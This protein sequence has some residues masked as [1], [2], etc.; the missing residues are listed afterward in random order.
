[1]GFFV[2]EE[3]AA[4]MLYK[5]ME[6]AGGGPLTPLDKLP[7]LP[8][9]AR[10]L[11]NSPTAKKRLTPLPPNFIR[12]EV[13]ENWPF[14]PPGVPMEVAEH[15]PSVAHHHRPSVPQPSDAALE[16]SKGT[17]KKGEEKKAIKDEKKVIKD[18]KKVIKDEKKLSK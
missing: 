4:E 10:P 3:D 11:A 5:Q 12:V 14:P 16:K 1:V 9:Y 2:E 15:R 18:E 13:D 7:P 8:Y 6:I 17:G